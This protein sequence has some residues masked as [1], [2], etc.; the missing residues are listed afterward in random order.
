VK[1]TNNCGLISKSFITR[2]FTLS[3]RQRRAC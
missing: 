1:P 3:Y 2:S